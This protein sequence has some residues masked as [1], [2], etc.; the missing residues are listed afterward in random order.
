MPL[1]CQ[2]MVQKFCL[3]YW[4]KQAMQQG[5]SIK[6]YDQKNAAS[7]LD[8]LFVSCG[9]PIKAL[10]D[11]THHEKRHTPSLRRRLGIISI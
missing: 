11:V 10:S 3:V 1:K 4:Y 6:G 8:F 7:L 2:K 9:I 5:R